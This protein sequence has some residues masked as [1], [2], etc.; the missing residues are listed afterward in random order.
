M[1]LEIDLDFNQIDYEAINRQIQ[2]K[3]DNMDIK[4]M[5]SL[6]SKVEYM[7]KDKV[8]RAVNG[9][10]T[11]G[12]W[13]GL[14]DSSRR[15]INDEIRK[16]IKELIEPHVKNI[17]NQLP[18]EELDKI[19]SDL[20]PKILMD[21]LNESMKNMITN[22]YYSAQNT[23]V[24]ICEERF[25]NI[26][27]RW[28]QSSKESKMSLEEKIRNAKETDWITDGIPKWQVSLIVFFA[29]L[30]VKWRRLLHK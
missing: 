4:D 10:L 17:F 9:Y 6:D 23:T 19:I 30:K 13:Q 22:Y 20:L 21:L 11:G 5:Y 25:R 14:N 18:Q 7:I 1:K 3:I 16:N 15:E 2:D 29:K 8:E 24:Q 27:G 28:N 12:V 26:L